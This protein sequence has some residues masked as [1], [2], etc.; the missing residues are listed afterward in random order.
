[1]HI[2]DPFD[3]NRAINPTDGKVEG[4]IR[5]IPADQ[6]KD[7]SAPTV[8]ELSGGFIIGYGSF[9]IAGDDV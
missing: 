1:M 6:I 8:A 9:K 3:T 2:V 5:M 4:A 7:P